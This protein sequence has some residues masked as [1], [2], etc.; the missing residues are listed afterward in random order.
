[1]H[2]PAINVASKFEGD[3]ESEEI[4]NKEVQSELLFAPRGKILRQLARMNLHR[5]K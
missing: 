5:N 3:N 1:M 4:I 2:R